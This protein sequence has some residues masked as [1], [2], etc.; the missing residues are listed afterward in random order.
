MDAK[1]L[2]AID[3]LLM[4]A[5]HFSESLTLKQSIVYILS[6]GFHY[7]LKE[8]AEMINT[9]ETAVKA[10]LFR[11]RNR[12]ANA[13]PQ[14]IANANLAEQKQAAAFIYEA[15]KEE[16]PLILIQAISVEAT[17]R[18]IRKN[19]PKCIQSLYMAA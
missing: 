12:L 8:V 4:L 7:Q 17:N 15:L 10:I 3:N 13:A 6:E 16:E 9:T 2:R 1:D 14:K 5:E 18:K 19:E 11:A